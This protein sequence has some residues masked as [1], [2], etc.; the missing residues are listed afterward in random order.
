M[1]WEA[2]G[3]FYALPR[4]IDRD[5]AAGRTVVANVSR[6]VIAAIRD[7]YVDVTGGIRHHAT[8]VCASA[9]RRGQQLLMAGVEERLGPCCR[10]RWPA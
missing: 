7:R 5:L 10:W 2:H 9:L 8:D 3:H 4:S 6:A 1:H